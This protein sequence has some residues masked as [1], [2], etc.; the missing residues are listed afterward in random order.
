MAIPVSGPQSAILDVLSDCVAIL[1]ASGVIVYTNQAWR[2]LASTVLTEANILVDGGN[3]L[4]RC[5]QASDP[6]GA[7][8]R[9]LAHGIRS[10][11]EKKQSSI[12]HD[13]AYMIHVGNRWMRAKLTGFDDGS[14]SFVIIALE[15]ISETRST[16]ERGG[17]LGIL[18]RTLFQMSAAGMLLVDATGKA[19]ESNDAFTEM[20]GRP[21]RDFWD[22][23]GIPSVRLTRKDGSP[24]PWDE[25]PAIIALRTCKPVANVEMSIVFPN[26]DTRWL[27]VSAQP[28]L[29]AFDAPFGAVVMF[30]NITQ[31]KMAEEALRESE[32]RFKSMIEAQ[33]ATMLL[34]DA[35]TGEIID[36]NGPAMKFYGYRRDDLLKMNVNQINTLTPEAVLELMHKVAT[37]GSAH[38][39]ARHRRADGQICDVEVYISTIVL[40]GRKINFQIIYD[41]TQRK[42]AEDQ[43][44]A[45][46]KQKEILLRE[47]HHRIKNNMSVIKGIIS[48]QGASVQDEAARRVLRDCDQ[49]ITTMMVLYDKLYRAVR[50]TALS[51]KQ[52]F[53]PLLEEIMASFPERSRITVRDEIEDIELGPQQLSYLGIVL[54]ELVT[55]AVR[56]AFPGGRRG[57]IT[58]S[59][60]AHE[61]GILFSVSDDGVGMHSGPDDP[62]TGGF[63]HGLVSMLAE[64]LE[65]MLSV[66][67]GEGTRWVLT[68]PRWPASIPQ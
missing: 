30:I 42:L 61:D 18:G 35:E 38:Y 51:A 26:G 39:E 6:E 67:S 40:R 49:R 65:G 43:V 31:R 37:E 11:L 32:E 17:Q 33:T 66:Q 29:D 5:E 57:T 36:A 52:Y 45:L 8:F 2:V 10:L 28:M 55:N 50:V 46:L 68:F 63:G 25:R 64:Q 24:F 13:T 22:S 53:S 4:L 59:C 27:L 14:A 1:D 16:N 56:H 41:V 7:S 47:V 62:F 23:G 44:M 19:A 48:L 54:N 15:A 34:I 60:A 9:E 58:V 21:A 20:F 3:F 12:V